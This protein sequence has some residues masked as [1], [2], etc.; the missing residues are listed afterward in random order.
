MII[1]QTLIKP[2]DP[3]KANRDY[4]IPSDFIPLELRKYDLILFGA[5]GF[6]GK[7]AAVYL[8]Q[9]YGGR[10]YNILYVCIYWKI[11]S[12][13][14]YFL[15]PFPSCII[16]LFFLLHHLD[17]Q[18]AKSSKVK[19]AIAGR[20][21]ENLNALRKEISRE[22]GNSDM[23]DVD[24]IIADTSNIDTLYNVVKDSRSVASTVGPYAVYGRL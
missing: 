10:D 18:I 2:I 24:V 5:T 13:E 19:W 3:N 22:V 15:P 4:Q 7:L 8:C 21:K 1:Q 9:Q 12:Y 20:S 17:E 6:T 23:M 14:T 11:P 16:L